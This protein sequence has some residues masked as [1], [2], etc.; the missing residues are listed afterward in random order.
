MSAISMLANA[1]HCKQKVLSYLYLFIVFV[2][3]K[4]KE[5]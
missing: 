2:E 4:I 3:Q 5:L 1:L